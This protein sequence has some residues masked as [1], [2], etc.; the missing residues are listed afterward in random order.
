MPVASYVT[1]F[2]EDFQRHIDE[3]GCPFVEQSPIASLYHEPFV[4]PAAG[5][6]P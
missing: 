4:T 3:G 5:V 2:R 1:H 6:A